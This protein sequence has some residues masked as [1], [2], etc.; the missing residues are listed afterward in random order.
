VFPSP[1]FALPGCGWRKSSR[2]GQ[3]GD[4]V[5]VSRPAGVLVRDTADRQGPVLEVTAVA[6]LRF[7]E[8]L[9]AG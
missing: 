5:E 6:W 8:A 4:C 2:S 7:T 1:D 9:K 3:N